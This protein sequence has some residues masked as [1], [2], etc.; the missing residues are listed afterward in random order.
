MGGFRQR[1]VLWLLT[2]SAVDVMMARGTLPYNRTAW[3]VAIRDVG[4]AGPCELRIFAV[5]VARQAFSISSFAKVRR[6]K[7]LHPQCKANKL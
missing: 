4:V 6:P 1:L 5:L 2:G 3:A 7:R